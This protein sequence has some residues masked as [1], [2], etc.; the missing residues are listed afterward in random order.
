VK[1]LS[2][3]CVAVICLLLANECYGLLVLYS[4]RRTAAL[5]IPF[6]FLYA[7]PMAGLFSGAVRAVINIFTA[8]RQ[9]HT[10]DPTGES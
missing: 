2:A 3:F 6:W 5:E 10:F 8:H 9:E 7:V 4:E 1:A